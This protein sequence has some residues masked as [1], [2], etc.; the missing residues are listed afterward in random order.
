MKTSDIYNICQVPLSITNETKRKG[1]SR[2]KKGAKYSGE[3]VGNSDNEQV[4][5][6]DLLESLQYTGCM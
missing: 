1:F 4:I 2:K 3:P 5:Y 6:L